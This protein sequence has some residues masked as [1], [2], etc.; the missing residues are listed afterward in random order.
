MGRC[1]RC[2][3]QHT[4]LVLTGP[5]VTG[6]QSSEE[7]DLFSDLDEEGSVDDELVPTGGH[8]QSSP[9]SELIGDSPQPD[10][11]PAPSLE[12]Q[13]SEPAAST[14]SSSGNLLPGVSD[15][16]LGLWA[17]HSA[18]IN[19]VDANRMRWGLPTSDNEIRRASLLLDMV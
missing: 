2:Q 15:T 7:S 3:L 4:V 13:M 6:S 9:G 18:Y 5:N 17:I 10:Q 14:S 1:A 12:S 16:S 8:A 11:P 19:A